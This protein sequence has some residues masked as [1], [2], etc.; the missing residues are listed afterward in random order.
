MQTLT[1]ARTPR[2]P[3]SESLGQETDLSRRVE[4]I[5]PTLDLEAEIKRLKAER[6]A[7]LLAH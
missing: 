7:V 1:I 6:N 3:A 4:T 5:D 2:N